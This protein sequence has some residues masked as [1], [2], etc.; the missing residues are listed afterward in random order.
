MKILVLGGTSFVGRHLVEAAVKIGHEVVLFNRGKTNPGVFSELRRIQGDRRKDAGLAGEEEWDAVFDTCAY[1]P[2]DLQP[3]VDVLK[4]KTKLYMFVSTI[5]VYNDYTNGRPIEASSTFEQ[6]IESD[7]VTGETYGPLKV[8]CEKLLKDQMNGRALIIRPCIIVGP[9]DPT[10]RFT[11]YAKRLS[12]D[13]PVAV[14]GGPEAERKVQWIDVRDMAEWIVKMAEER[15]TG[16]Y[17]AASD[18]ISMSDFID[19]IS[20]AQV[21]KEWIPD[22]TLDAAELGIRRYPF[23]LPISKEY[24]EGFIIVDNRLAVENGLSFRPLAATA[25][26]TREWAADREMKA[27]PTRNQ[28]KLLL[29]AK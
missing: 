18:P 24:P 5:S 2:Q 27:G 29:N 20:S 14:P 1:S 15:K 25:K 8:M 10:D 22:K 19:A 12:E 16:T 11:Y 9:H 23:W 4:N 21:V 28:E 26:D 17:N 13:G 7:E 3:M 6:I